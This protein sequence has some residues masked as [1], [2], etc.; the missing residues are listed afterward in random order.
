MTASAA[1]A[2][3]VFVRRLGEGA[4]KTLA[5]HCTIAHSGV[6]SGLAKAMDGNASLVAPD[7]LS[8]GRSPDWDGQGDFFDHVTNNAAAEL[9]G[10]MDVV[11]HSFGAIIALRLALEHP[12][13]VRSLILIEPVFFAIAHRDAPDL[14]DQHEK[15][16]EP[17]NSA[18]NAGENALAARLFNRMWSTGIS[19]KWPDLPERTRA[20]MVRGI[21]A[22]PA[23]HPVLYDDQAGLLKAEMLERAVMPTL[24]LSGSETHP[25]IPA[26]CAGLVHRLPYARHAVVQGA[27]HMLPISHPQD[28]AALLKAFWKP[29]PIAS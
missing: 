1:S 6:W 22:V 24:I 14:F 26:I 17:I 2:H 21:H 23:V 13:R 20:N 11:G 9:A 19:P 7:M 28:T 4:R 3:S 25:V 29:I 8:H 16:I 18:F 12:E 27:G 15:D 5:L 10:Q